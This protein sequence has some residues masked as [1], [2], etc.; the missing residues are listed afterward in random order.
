MLI[1]NARIQQARPTG[2]VSACSLE[3][4]NPAETAFDFARI[5]QFRW[6]FHR[7]ANQPISQTGKGVLFKNRRRLG[8]QHLS[9]VAAADTY[10]RLLE[11][12]ATIVLPS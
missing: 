2:S 4:L 9:S 11:S 1:N 7:I 12:V 3:G 5:E 10:V 8:W 6:R